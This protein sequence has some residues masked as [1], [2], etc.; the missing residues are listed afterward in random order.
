MMTNPLQ[1]KILSLFFFSPSGLLVSSA[2]PLCDTEADRPLCILP[3]S[4]ADSLGVLQPPVPLLCPPYFLLRT[5]THSEPTPRTLLHLK[6]YVCV[7]S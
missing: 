5:S 1:Q 2:Q 6:V 3:C 4:A 7:V